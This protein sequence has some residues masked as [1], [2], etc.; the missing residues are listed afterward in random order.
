MHPHSALRCL[1][2]VVGSLA[3]SSCAGPLAPVVIDGVA[4]QRLTMEYKGRPYS[5]RHSGAHP[6]PGNPSDGTRAEG[7]TIAG[8][9]CGSD[10]HYQVTHNGD[11]VRVSGFINNE[12]SATLEIREANNIRRIQGGLGNFIVDVVLTNDTIAGTVGR[13]GYEL[14][15]GEANNDTFAQVL[16]TQGFNITMRINGRPELHKLPAADQAALVPLMLYC[17]TAKVFENFGHD[18]PE[19]GFGSPEGAQPPKTINFGPQSNRS[20]GGT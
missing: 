4:V 15:P 19:L 3:L 10:I 2:V 18:P 5:I 13:C 1:P 9:V 14:H 6:R 20:C 8:T 12:Q 7:G 16:R 17:A 11:H